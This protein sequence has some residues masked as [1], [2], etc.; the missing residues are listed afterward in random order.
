MLTLLVLLALG[1]T[2]GLS[3]ALIPGPLLTFTI[4]TSLKKGA[5]VGPLVVF[6][7]I[8]SEICVILLLFGGL[9]LFLQTALFQ[10]IV[11]VI[12]G[13]ALLFLAFDLFRTGAKKISLI[14]K[15][16]KHHGLI[17][18]GIIFSMFNPSFPLWWVTIGNANLLYSFE[19]AGLLGTISFI[20]GHWFSD[21]G[22][23]SFISYS[24]GRGKH[25]IGNRAY[26]SLLL[27]CGFLMFGLGIYF[28]FKYTFL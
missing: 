15:S 12:G 18:G 13:F 17:A 5:K 1:F 7:H 21:L 9:A 24:I 8:L 22:W 25:F 6:G 23:Y 3:G 4:S 14:D 27:T 28:L 10:K 11:G 16:S 20:I 19:I 2:I 26:R